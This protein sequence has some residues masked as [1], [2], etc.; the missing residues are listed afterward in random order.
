MDPALSLKR[1]SQKFPKSARLLSSGHFKSLIQKGVRRFGSSV[2][3]HFRLG[4]SDEPKLGI[5]VSR[6]YGKAHDRNRFK[7]V[8]REAFREIYHTLPKDLEL[9]VFPVKPQPS[10]KDR[11]NLFPAGISKEIVINELRQLLHLPLC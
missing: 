1:P 6:K 8:V 4:I 9:N 5:T 3:I 11:P 2:S 7:R 10:S